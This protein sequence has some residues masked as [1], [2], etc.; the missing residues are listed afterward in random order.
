M[1]GNYVL[2]SD[3]FM[4]QSEKRNVSLTILPLH[5][6]VIQMMMMMKSQGKERREQRIC[7]IL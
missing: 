6:N 4:F 3:M 7:Q 1:T 5:K 2:S